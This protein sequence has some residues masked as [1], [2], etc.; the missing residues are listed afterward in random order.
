MQAVLH[1]VATEDFSKTFVLRIGA[2]VKCARGSKKENDDLHHS[3]C[4]RTA[5]VPA[6]A[7]FASHLPAVNVF[8]RHK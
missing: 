2:R 4:F 3:R 5:N 8:G 6:S 1:Q 7:R